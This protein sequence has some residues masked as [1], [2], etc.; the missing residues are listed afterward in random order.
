MEI[1]IVEVKGCGDIDEERVTLK[2]LGDSVRTWDYA[3]IDNTYDA[4]GISN[5][6]RHLY[7]F[8]DERPY[9]VLNEG[10]LIHLYTK[11]GN[12]RV[13]SKDD[14]KVCYYYWG[15]KKS[16]WNKDGDKVSLLEIES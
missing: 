16:I 10:D 4:D 6:H 14:K 2:V 12:N 13:L 11:S 15:L 9:E 8:D 7:Y 5:K 1:E 3:I